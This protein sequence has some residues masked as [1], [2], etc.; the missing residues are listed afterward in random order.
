MSFILGIEKVSD[1]PD[2]QTFSE[3]VTGNFDRKAMGAL[4]MSDFMVISGLMNRIFIIDVVPDG[5]R[6]L[7]FRYSGTTLDEQYG[8]NLMGRYFEDF[9]LGSNREMVIGNLYDAIDTGKAAYLRQHLYIDA[10]KEKYR[11]AE[12][13]AFPVAKNGNEVEQLIGIVT[14]SPGSTDGADVCEL[15]ELPSS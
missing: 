7:L 1:N 10:K 15:F 13:L 3:F 9:F 8:K 11:L 12:R 5:D 4:D 2:L 14:F 6:R